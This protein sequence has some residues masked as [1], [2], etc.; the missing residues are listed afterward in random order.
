MSTY[1]TNLKIE[2]IGQGEQSGVWGNTTNTNLGTAVE[3]AVVGLATLTA[4]DFTTN[5][6]TL[7]AS[8]LATAQNFRA[9]CLTI[10]A[11]SLSAAGTINV[12]AI[13]KP[14]I[15]VN[16]DI[17]AVTVKVSGLTGV[18]VPA[19]KRTVVYN[20]GTDVGDQISF[21]SGLTLGTALPIASGGTGSTTLA[22]ASIATYTGT[23][24]LT[25]KTI[26]AGVFTNGYTEEVGTANTTTAFTIDLT[27]G[28]V[29]IL[30]LTGNC[31]FTFP[32][33]TA[34]KSFLLFL[35]QDATGSRTASWPA[36]VKWPS[37]TAPT[38]TNTANKVD[39]F[40]F[41]ADGTYWLGS[42]GGQNYL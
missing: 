12:P 10:S 11:S 40:V 2:L 8:N 33:P 27:A 5:V 19:G 22:G 7:T 42:V 13:Q 25:N 16:N 21:L 4:A 36:S 9:L 35:K 20:N 39:K 15:I 37:N 34:G 41:T 23:E 1:S 24:T 3:Q 30:T 31:T 17:Y 26:E 38:I 28:S 32:T 14:Y 6:A 29:Q 18:S